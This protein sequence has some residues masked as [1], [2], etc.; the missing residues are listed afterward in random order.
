MTVVGPWSRRQGLVVGAGDVL[1][2]GL[3]AVGAGVGDG[4]VLV[5]P[6]V[7]G[8]VE[9]GALVLLGDEVGDGAVLLGAGVDPVLVDVP[10]DVGDGDGDGD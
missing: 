6:E 5:D 4:V 9:G 8:L 7:V 3:S 10:G 1:V 2:V